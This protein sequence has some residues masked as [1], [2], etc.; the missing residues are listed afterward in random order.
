MS[1]LKVNPDYRALVRGIKDALEPSEVLHIF[2][3]TVESVIDRSRYTTGIL[4]EV[5][6]ID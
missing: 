3:D 2:D 6:H 4:V 1:K 5:D